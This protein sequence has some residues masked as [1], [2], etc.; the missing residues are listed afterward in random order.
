MLGMDYYVI[1]TDG[2][3]Y[4]PA[5]MDTLKQWVG[6]QRILPTTMLKSFANGQTLA[7][8]AVPGLFE[9]PPPVAA[10]Q[11]NWTQPPTPYVRPQ[12][13]YRVDDGKYDVIWALVRST[14]ALVFFFLLGGIG[15]FFAGY[16]VMY[17]FRARDKGHQHANL[18]IGISICAL[19][20][21]LIGWAVRLSSGGPAFR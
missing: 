10:A 13:M 4:G 9:I 8:S 15:V 20:L 6:E 7:A 5:T 21:V 11:Q 17:A 12:Q 1:G 3:Q 18:A 16:A 14:L 19:V 2:Q